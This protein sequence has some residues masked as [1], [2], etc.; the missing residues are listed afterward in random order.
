[1]YNQEQ[2]LEFIN[3]YLDKYEMT[4]F[5]AMRLGAVSVF[6]VAD[7]ET[8]LEQLPDRV[9]IEEY[10]SCPRC[11]TDVSANPRLS[12]MTDGTVLCSCG[13]HV[14]PETDKQKRYI[15]LA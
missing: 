6:S 5:P 10:F 15:K 1:M 13:G 7:I 11:D 12:V 4:K 14:N 2:V 3:L 8:A 9:Q